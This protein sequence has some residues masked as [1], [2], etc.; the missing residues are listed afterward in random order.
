MCTLNDLAGTLGNVARIGLCAL[1]LK[2]DR[3]GA[4]IYHEIT[5]CHSCIECRHKFPL[6][7]VDSFPWVPLSL[8]RLL[9]AIQSHPF[10][11]FARCIMECANH[12]RRVA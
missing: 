10:R 8:A 6:V 11:S 1:E 4:C 2:L 9:A 3:Y 12:E 5:E 7:S